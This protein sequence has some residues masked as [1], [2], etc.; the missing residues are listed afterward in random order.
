MSMKTKRFLY[1]CSFLLA[2]VLLYGCGD[3]TDPEADFDEGQEQDGPVELAIVKGEHGP[4][5]DDISFEIISPAPDEV[6]KGDSITVHVKLQSNEFV[7]RAPTQGEG[8]NNLA[9]SKDGQHIHLI[10]D[11]EPY[12]AKYDTTFSIGGLTPGAHTL[13]A[14]PSRSWHESIKKPGS[15]VAHTFYVGLKNG[16]PALKADQ[17]LLTYSRP[18]GE[19]VGQDAGEIMLDFYISSCVLAPDAYKVITSIDEKVIDTLRDWTPYK[20]QGLEEGEHT[21]RLQLIDPNG[22]PVVNGDF[23]DTERT[24]TVKKKADTQKEAQKKE[25]DDLEKDLYDAGRHSSGL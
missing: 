16:E 2:G 4:M 15:F 11:N 5:F 1:P 6:V 9:Y 13:R 14:F 18:K 22:N 20:I 25:E 24:I 8:A 23:N 3:D 12:M 10:I 17:P 7:L 21:I 19:Y